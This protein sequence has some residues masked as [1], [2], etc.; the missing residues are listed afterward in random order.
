[1]H[2][3]FIAIL[4][5][6]ILSVGTACSSGPDKAE[7]EQL[8]DRIVS[9]EVKSAGAAGAKDLDKQ[10][11]SVHDFVKSDF[12]KQCMERTS[13]EKVQCALKARSKADLDKCDGAKGS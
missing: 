12:M 5:G 1:M 9:L 3:Y 13:K 10:K 8:L 7:C 6:L 4:A 2:R 11:K